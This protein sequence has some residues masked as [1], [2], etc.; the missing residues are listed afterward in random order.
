MDFIIVLIFYFF[1]LR[2][3]INSDRR[4]FNNIVVTFFS[5]SSTCIT[6]FERKKTC[7]DGGHRGQSKPTVHPA[8]DETVPAGISAILPN[9]YLILYGQ[10][11]SDDYSYANATTAAEITTSGA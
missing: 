3:Q 1:F 5:P 6:V 2:K 4:Y 10:Q 7:L 11:Y 8:G 9:S